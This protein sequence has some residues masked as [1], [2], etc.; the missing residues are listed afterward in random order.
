MDAQVLAIST[1]FTPTLDHWK[2]ELHADFPMLSDHNRKVS[3][4]YGILIPQLGIANRVTFVVDTDGKI[5]SIQEGKEALDPTGAETACS[6][7]KHK[8]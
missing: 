7:I 3:E 4:Q 1:D 8:P 6:R 5:V 2:K